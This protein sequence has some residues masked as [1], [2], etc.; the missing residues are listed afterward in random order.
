MGR[1]SARYAKRPGYQTIH[2]FVGGKT[3]EIYFK[4]KKEEIK[5]ETIRIE[6]A[7]LG[8]GK[9]PRTI[10]KRA[11]QH[12][13][14]RDFSSEFNDECWV[15]FDEDRDKQNLD[16]AIRLAQK[17]NIHVAY[18]NVCFELWFLLHFNYI[19]AAIGAVEY[20]SKLTNHIRNKRNNRHYQYKKT[21]SIY[22]DIIPYE[23]N[24]IRNAGKLLQRCEK[25]NCWECDPSTTVHI[26]VE[27]LNKLRQQ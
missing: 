11:I 3:E 9:D 19:D 6:I 18:S 14:S 24:A 15:V 27:R 23:K 2:I 17:S 4:G 20:I 7:P 21:E 13:E 8:I 10:V 25:S 16:E 1:L 22:Q 5:R 26:L 12:T